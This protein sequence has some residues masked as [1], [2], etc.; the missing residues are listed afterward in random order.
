MPTVESDVSPDTS[1]SP[2][3]QGIVRGLLPLYILTRLADGSAYGT[4]I[5]SGIATMTRGLWLP[6]PGSLYPTLKR[7][8]SEGHIE[9]HWERG[10]AAPRRVYSLTASG[11]QL[12]DHLR[13]SLISDLHAARDV[14][15][16]H[17]EALAQPEA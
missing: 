15:G 13:G 17:L 11:R 10:P 6:S 12:R 7:L 4:E 9:G 14:I 2:V 5:S 16:V 8:E 3:L 1:A